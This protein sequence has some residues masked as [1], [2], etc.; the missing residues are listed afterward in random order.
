MMILW[1]GPFDLPAPAAG[2]FLESIPFV[3]TAASPLVADEEGKAFKKY[4]PGANQ[5]SR[6][7]PRSFVTAVCSVFSVRRPSG[8]VAF[9]ARTLAF[10]IGC[11]A[12]SVIRP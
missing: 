7:S 1:S 10:A 3:T 9:K 6:Y 4:E 5:N 8:Y 12:R 11:P 2:S